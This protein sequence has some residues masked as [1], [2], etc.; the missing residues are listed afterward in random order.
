MHRYVLQSP[1]V[2]AICALFLAKN[3]VFGQKLHCYIVNIAFCTELNVQICNYGQNGAF[4][5]KIA[6]TRLTK[7]F[8]AFFAVR[9]DIL[10]VKY[11]YFTFSWDQLKLKLNQEEKKAIESRY[12]LER[13]E[14]GVRV[15]HRGHTR[16]SV[17]ILH[18]ES[19]TFPIS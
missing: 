12:L 10:H 4:V 17:T 11:Y 14:V 8:I 5:A 3:S 7:I 6:N 1:P 13:C 9:Q 15:E 16:I 19:V 18:L 2:L